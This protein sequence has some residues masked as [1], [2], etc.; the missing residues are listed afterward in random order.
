MDKITLSASKIKLFETCSWAYYCKYHL[1]LKDPPNAGAARGTVSHLIF[2]ILLKERHRK[3]FDK[4]ISSQNVESSPSITRL[5]NKTSKKLGVAHPEHYEM[6]K[7]MILVGLNNNF[8]CKE[9][10]KVEAESEF[11]I[12]N[13]NFIINGFIDKKAGYKDGSIEVFDYK[14]SKSKFTE[15]EINFNLQNLMYSLACFKTDGKIPKV[16][17]I[18][19]RFP[20]K[21]NQVAP[22]CTTDILKGFEEYLTFIAKQMSEFNVAIAKEN[23]AAKCKEK[24]WL[25]GK[26]EYRGQRKNDGSLIWGCPFKFGFEYYALIDDKGKVLNTSLENDLTATD[27]QVIVKKTYAGC[28]AF[29][30]K[31]TFISNF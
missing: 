28:P 12:E 10:V 18:F 22:Q 6:I 4:I 11:K 31:T 2:E 21:P 7:Q 17:F 27:K 30:K 26:N 25:C 5:I 13:N 20:K 1:K 14:S 29:S 16:T 24:K 8:L 15:D 9:A 23:V 3:E 19:L